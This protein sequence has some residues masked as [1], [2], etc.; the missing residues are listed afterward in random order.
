MRI[1]ELLAGL[2]IVAMLT[3]CSGSGIDED[4]PID[5]IAAEAAQ[6]GQ[7]ELQKMVDK[8]QAV[9]AD[10][11]KELDSIKNKIKDIPLTEMAGEKANALKENI[12][13]VTSSLGKLKD[14]M[15]AYAKELAA[16]E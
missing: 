5:Q 16:K 6:M 4:K 3:G 7:V 10:K 14:Q 9:I 1:Q 13:E 11:T 12:S 2:M 15:A 8:Y